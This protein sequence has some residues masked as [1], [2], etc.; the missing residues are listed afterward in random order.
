MGNL[1]D[2]IEFHFV[3]NVPS[4]SLTSA[5]WLQGHRHK[6]GN[7]V[8]FPISI[9]ITASNPSNN[10]LACHK[11]GP[12]M[13]QFVCCW[14]YVC[15][16]INLLVVKETFKWVE[17]F[18]FQFS[19]PTSSD[20]GENEGSTGCQI[21]LEIFNLLVHRC[22]SWSTRDVVLCHNLEEGKK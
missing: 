14:K 3:S 17:P 1:D 13:S 22:H 9:S 20:H 4:H 11:D 16:V 19:L 6:L 15:T 10:I 8:A 18:E 2:N 12:F 5:P 21:L 7:L